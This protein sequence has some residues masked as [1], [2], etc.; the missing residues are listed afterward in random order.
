MKCKQ[1]FC[2]K[3]PRITVPSTTGIHKLIKNVRSN[4]S[5]LEKKLVTNAVHLPTKKTDE[6]EDRSEQ[7]TPQ[8]TLKC[9]AQQMGI[10]NCQHPK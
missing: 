10:K 4:G 9:L 1:K 3:F 2:L 7:H 5:P 6:L 8:K